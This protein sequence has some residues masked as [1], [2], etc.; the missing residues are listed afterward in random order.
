MDFTL[1][2]LLVVIAILSILAALLVPA[3]KE[4][5]EAGRQ[6][7]CTSNLRQLAIAEMSSANDHDGKFYSDYSAGGN[8]SDAHEGTWFRAR[9]N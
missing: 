2:E 9:D 5:M 7:L 8:S 4:A 3:V 1:I 6:A